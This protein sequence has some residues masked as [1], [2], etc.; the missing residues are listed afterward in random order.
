MN[1]RVRAP[2]TSRKGIL[3]SSRAGVSFR[4][5]WRWW[6][7]GRRRTGSSWRRS[8]LHEK[9]RGRDFPTV[10]NYLRVT[11]CNI[12]DEFAK[13]MD[14]PALAGLLGGQNG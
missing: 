11:L 5:G 9:L 7:V 2:V 10:R 12:H 1:I 13:R 4:L 8:T 14:A 6:G 3:G